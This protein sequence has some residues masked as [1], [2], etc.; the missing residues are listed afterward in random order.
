[1]KE[2]QKV[3][4]KTLEEGKIEYEYEDHYRILAQNIY[5]KMEKSALKSI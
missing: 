4:F 1:M 5:E 2:G 3:G